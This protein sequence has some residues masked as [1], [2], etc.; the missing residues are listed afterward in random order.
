[1]VSGDLH[2][3]P[4]EELGSDISMWIARQ[5]T[6]SLSTITAIRAAAAIL[7]SKHSY[8]DHV[9]FD[10]TVAW[11]G[12][13][14]PQS[15]DQRANAVGPMTLPLD[16]ELELK[17]LID[18]IER[19][20]SAVFSLDQA[21]FQT[22]SSSSSGDMRNEMR[23]IVGVHR[24]RMTDDEIF[25]AVEKGMQGQACSLIVEYAPVINESLLRVRV[26]GGVHGNEH[27]ERVFRSFEL[28]LK[29]L[30]TKPGTTK[31]C[32]LSPIRQE[33]VRDIWRWNRTPLQTVDACAHH[34]IEQQVLGQPD[35]VAIC[36]WDGEL[37][38]A[39]LDQLSSRLAFHL[40]TTQKVS[41]DT[42]VPLC[43]EKS[44]W[45]V[46]A[47]LAVLKAGGAFVPLDPAHPSSRL[48]HI[49]GQV[50][51]TFVLASPQHAK[52]CTG[53]VDDVFVVTREIVEGLGGGGHFSSM[54]VGLSH[55]AYIIFTS[56][57]TG[58]PK[59][60]TI[61]HK[62]VS[63]SSVLGGK[64]M[65][66]ESRPR[67]L[68]FASYTFDACILE[69][70]T[71]L[72]YGGCV[73]V[74]S[75]WQRMNDI[76]R[77]MNEAKVTCAF[78]TPS[79]LSNIP[80]ADLQTLDT[81]IV[82]GERIPSD[83]I[84][85]WRKNVRLIMAYG[86]TE[87]CVICFTSDASK[88][89][90]RGGDIGHAVGGKSWI[91]DEKNPDVL[92]PIGNVGELL[93]EGP[94]LA[95][96][97][98]NDEIKT[99]AAFIHNPV[100]MPKPARLYK[101]GDLVRYN[102][103]GSISFVSRKDTQVKVRG[104]RL[105][106]GEVEQQIR[107]ALAPLQ[108]EVAAEVV[109]PA[110]RAGAPVLVAFVSLSPTTR[111]VQ[112]SSLNGRPGLPSRL[113]SDLSPG[114]RPGLLSRS[115]SGPIVQRRPNLPSRVS[116][117][118]TSQSRPSLR[119]STTS[120][121]SIANNPC[122]P[123]VMGSG[124]GLQSRPSV[125]TRPSF[126]SNPQTRPSL[127]ARQ[128]STSRFA[129]S[130]SS[131]SN[132]PRFGSSFSNASDS[133]SLTGSASVFSDGSWASS[134]T[135]SLNGSE[136]LEPP[137]KMDEDLPKAL[138]GI[139]GTL[140]QILPSYMIPSAFIPL[141][142][143]PLSV[144]GKIDRR[145]LRQMAAELSQEKLGITNTTMEEQRPMTEQEKQM[146]TLWARELNIKVDG[147]VIDSNF[148]QLGGDSIMAMRLVAS[149][150]KSGL[151]ITVDSIFKNPKLSEL[152]NI[153][154]RTQN[155]TDSNL[156]RVA[157]FSLLGSEILDHLLNEAADQCRT[158]KDMI[159]DIYPCTPLQ[160][161]LMAL[162]VKE[163][164][165]YIM[166]F[167]YTLPASLDIERFQTAWQTV[168]T[169]NPILRT[170]FIQTASSALMQV[171]L[172]D[173]IEWVRTG[174]AAVICP[175]HQSR[176]TNMSF[177]QPMASYTITETPLS[178]GYTFIWDVHHSV[179]DGWS[180]SQIIGLVEQTY[181]GNPV[182]SGP[183]FNK[184]ISYLLHADQKASEQ[185]WKSELAS[186]PPP[187][188]PRPPSATYRPCTNACMKHR[189]SLLRE[190]GSEITMATMVR[191]AWSLLVARYSNSNDA[192]F[193]VTL[194]GRNAQFPGV[195]S[196]VGPTITTAPLRV[197]FDG[198]QSVSEYL[199]AVQK[200]A[201]DMMPYEHFGLTKIKQISDEAR[202]CCDFQNLLIVQPSTA[203]E[204]DGGPA[205]FE[206]TDGSTSES[207]NYALVMEC[208][209]EST[210]VHLCS[211]YDV[212]VIDTIQMERLLEQFQH[213]LEQLSLEEE[214]AKVRDVRLTSPSDLAEILQWN[215]ITPETYQECLQHLIQCQFQ[216]RPE[217]PALCAWD[218]DMTYRELYTLS[219]RLA[220][221]LQ[222]LGVG[223]EVY[224]PLCFEKSVWA[225]VSML[226][227]LIAGGVCV[228]L[229]PCHPAN[230]R[231]TIIEDAGSHLVLCSPTQAS[232]FEQSPQQIVTIEPRVFKELST[233]VDKLRDTSSP[234]D[235]AYVIFT[236]GSTGKPKGIVIEHEALCTS[237]RN[238]GAVMKLNSSS[239][240]L[241]FAAY[242]FDISFSDIF[243]TLVHGGC[244]CI[245]SDHDRMNN[246]ESAMRSLNVNQACLTTTVAS[247]LR[248]AEI[249]GLK[250][251]T[252]AGEAPTEEI[253]NL[254][255]E[256]VCLV[257]MYGPAECTIYA[258]GRSD[259]RKTDIPENMGTGVGA[260]LWITDVQ[261]HHTLAP[262]G[263]IGE[264]LIEGPILA[265]SYLKDEAKTR[266][267]FVEDPQWSSRGE[268][269]RPRRFYK[270]GDLVRYGSDGSVLY[271]GRKDT[272][273]KVRGQRV[274]LGEIEHQIRLCT[275]TSLELAVEAVTPADGNGK[276]TIAAFICVGADTDLDDEGSIIMTAPAAC[277]RLR[278]LVQGFES[279][280]RQ[281]L[282]QYMIP[283]LYLPLSR[284]PIS[285]SAKTDRRRLRQLASTLTTRQLSRF[286]S[287]LMQRRLPSTETEKFL[288]DLWRQVLKTSVDE[289]IAAEDD[290]FR[291]GGDSITAMR[292]VA[293]A[294][295][296]GLVLTVNNIFKHPTLAG[297][298][299]AAKQVQ[300]RPVEAIAPFTLLKD[301]ST[302]ASHLVAEVATLCNSQQ[303][304]IEDIYPATPCQVSTMKW[305][306]QWPLA[307]KYPGGY[308]IQF[309]F[310]LRR[311]LDIDKFRFAWQSAV[312]REPVLRTRLVEVPSGIFQVVFNSPMLWKTARNLDTFLE[313]DKKDI[314]GY[315][316]PLFRY[317][318]VEEEDSDNRFFVWTAHHAVYDGWSLPLIFSEVEAAF[319]QQS[320]N[321]NSVKY[322]KFIEHMMKVE[323]E[324]SDQ[325]W[326]SHFLGTRAKPF[327]FWR[328]P[329]DCIVNTTARRFIAFSELQRSNI[330]ISTMVHLAWSLLHAAYTQ[331]GDVVLRLV[332][333]GRDW[334]VTGIET[335]IGPAFTHVPFRVRLDYGQKT[336]D[337][338]REIQ[339]CLAATIPYQ[340]AGMQRIRALD[341]E[342][343]AACDASVIIVVQPTSSSTLFKPPPGS[344]FVAGHPFVLD[345]CPLAMELYIGTDDLEVEARYDS[346]CFYAEGIESLLRQFESIFRQL[347]TAGPEHTLSDVELGGINIGE[348]FKAYGFQDRK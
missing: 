52:K 97:Y 192:T 296:V 185:F 284:L 12:R 60:V 104:Q 51:A 169:Q 70:I 18:R 24:G 294:R 302:S 250:I 193:G 99:K 338:L 311:E 339:D 163:V 299:G 11:S 328:Q 8:C 248:P 1:M 54:A 232:L 241:Q 348:V 275:S 204:K 258:A 305:D 27:S 122:F 235:A 263:A 84:A 7:L 137:L 289:T 141:S 268:L 168:V 100:W 287:G 321:A 290:F 112:S 189:V 347:S 303:E 41:P 113:H 283:T 203:S 83:L 3:L 307:G 14:P 146:Q 88:I 237:I 309:V 138:T 117:S 6:S 126:S 277:Q 312:S 295:D 50:G 63:T 71:T 259:I 178:D 285:T 255:A 257:N 119:S 207:L 304:A 291:L 39:E 53:I 35:A 79:L 47:M 211:R 158:Q 13:L 32:D 262:V 184:F 280:L 125:S 101:T 33:D 134:T 175:Q 329:A 150:R 76:V 94:I 72:I 233:A 313:Q 278:T 155:V 135:E 140:S 74:P 78:F 142:R 164:G 149:A 334:P 217:S 31:V 224:V 187:S 310:S 227:V 170:R 316:D 64:A 324:T 167:V 195:E 292:L 244:V 297:M 260:L 108:V 151:A 266:A 322:N 229:D 206:M 216:K 213:V 323:Q 123:A 22:I 86:P 272:Q 236:S 85:D 200:Q 143:M 320:T 115:V 186:A 152:S 29:E 4:D 264:L 337:F 219:S 116:I 110:A 124:P 319:H 77:F 273:I 36:S 145:Q 274:E 293:T 306:I 80:F 231:R 159:E 107:A 265:R 218:G 261:D 317:C 144:S 249:P 225:V 228:P 73:C 25:K 28:I 256:K 330:T 34:L 208:V 173:E 55:A 49:I 111:G 205:L 199:R 161:G 42:F 37:T 56:G 212:N 343:K 209:L 223:P 44:M 9:V 276:P 214:S 221:H 340:A 57:S 246:L 201:V 87:C 23:V 174:D 45:T 282:P 342:T 48:E 40:A 191:A 197:R 238:H 62:Q 333:T 179:L 198:D 247:Q 188:F 43:F 346:R 318:I 147:I 93:I 166:R 254:W 121:S 298:A 226:A 165:T 153:A 331:T 344:E 210:G 15:G 222:G 345:A 336:W 171:V 16:D 118:V 46:V 279:R 183:P 89:E 69:I 109:T 90:P 38:Y 66:F 59:G 98:I 92:V 325:F 288:Q 5:G 61:E 2:G 251:L 148:F 196:V 120:T 162:S 82:G 267:A 127:P 102:P 130:L 136:S 10:P 65:G 341:E 245:P 30:S 26:M 301:H 103:D 172:K 253:L 17:E 157:P 182:S 128:S 95:R 327:Y 106:L 156:E 315:T 300:T 270:T 176:M 286:C 180:Q 243:A 194:S 181:L 96:G 215:H 19:Q 105:E 21:D 58:L 75:D 133:S 332:R 335:M 242:T 281:V 269:N 20:A 234:N 91:V 308:A 239:R 230:R 271:I 220:I 154:E 131:G 240:F 252:I 177:G 67:M 114:G 132:L 129:A 326:R 160:D 81:V 139:T 314:M 190:G 68:Q 202:A